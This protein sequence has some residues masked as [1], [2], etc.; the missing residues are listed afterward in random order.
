MEVRTKV[1]S[2]SAMRKVLMMAAFSAG[3]W[4][5]DNLY[6]GGSGNYEWGNPVF[7]P[8]RKKFKGWQ[9]QARERK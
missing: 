6:F 3:L 2:M 4:A 8:K 1:G 5:R 7:S 9:R